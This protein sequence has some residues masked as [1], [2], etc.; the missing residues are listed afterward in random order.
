MRLNTQVCQVEK[1]VISVLAPQ[2]EL[3]LLTPVGWLSLNFKKFGG[4]NAALASQS[5]DAR[6]AVSQVKIQTRHGY[7]HIY[8]VK[9][10]ET[11][12]AAEVYEMR[13]EGSMVGPWLFPCL[14][15]ITW[16]GREVGRPELKQM[17]PRQM[18]LA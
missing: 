15:D 13:K 12:P 5:A 6:T 9:A 14:T 7:M 17:S 10:S 2:A 11:E 18:E 16:R 4:C 1:L 3:C 8:G